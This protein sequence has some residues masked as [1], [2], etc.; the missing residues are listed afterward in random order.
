[1]GKSPTSF[2]AENPRPGP[3]RPTA[4]A[5]MEYREAIKRGLP[6]KALTTT[7]EHARALAGIPT[8]C[9]DKDGKILFEKFT[10]KDIAQMDKARRYLQFFV[11]KLL[12][13][14]AMI[15]ADTIN[16]GDAQAVMQRMRDV[17]E[18]VG[19]TIRDMLA[20]RHITPEQARLFIAMFVEKINS[21]REEDGEDVLDIE[22]D[23]DEESKDEP[24]QLSSGESPASPEA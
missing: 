19:D 11:G 24:K 12:P 13:D 20:E 18:L 1:M 6:H 3:G 14:S 10:L 9:V 15:Q 22:A 8:H 2:S 7:I 4:K 23:L 16:I 21:V 17:E 5:E